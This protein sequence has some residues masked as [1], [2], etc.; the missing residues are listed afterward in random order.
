MRRTTRTVGMLVA[1]A[2]LMIPLATG[3][4]QGSP[5]A[6]NPTPTTPTADELPCGAPAADELLDEYEGLTENEAAALAGAQ[7]LTVRVVGRDGECFAVTDDL[8][9]DRVNLYLEE[10]VVVWAAIF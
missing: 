2:A 9:R 6:S 4:G 8:R 1:A 7:V 3:C 10:G 5:G